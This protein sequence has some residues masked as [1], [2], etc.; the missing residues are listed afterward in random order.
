M[1]VKVSLR[2]NLTAMNPIFVVVPIMAILLT[3]GPTTTVFA[4]SDDQ[5]QQ[6]TCPDGSQPDENGNCPNE[7]QQ[8]PSI[9]DEICNALQGNNIITL[10]GLLIA[11]HLLTVGASTATILAVAGAY[12]GL[13]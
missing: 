4:Q 10:A 12:C 1:T 6:Q 5:Q 13:G 8:Q 9:H 7:Q 11:L 2:S 3:A